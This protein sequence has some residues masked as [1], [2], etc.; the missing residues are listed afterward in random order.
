MHLFY[1]PFVFYDFF[2]AYSFLLFDQKY[3]FA[4]NEI[5]NLTTLALNNPNI[6]VAGDWYCNEETQKTIN[7]IL[8]I[9]RN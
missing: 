6:V 9:I 2:S 5:Q 3:M 4:K 7:N 1:P 8:A